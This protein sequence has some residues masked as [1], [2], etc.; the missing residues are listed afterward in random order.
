M[1]KNKTKSLAAL[2]IGNIIFH[3]SKITPTEIIKSVIL[4]IIT[5]IV[6]VTDEDGTEET[7]REIVFLVWGDTK[8][9]RVSGKDVIQDLEN[10]RVIDQTEQLGD[11]PNQRDLLEVLQELK[12]TRGKK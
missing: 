6:I 12:S 5:K 2:S 1:S 11:E 4:K 9:L 10:L 3:Q 7:K 8:D